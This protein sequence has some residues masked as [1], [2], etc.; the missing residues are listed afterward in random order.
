[1]A[2]L[3]GQELAVRRAIG[4]T[5]RRLFQALLMTRSL[6]GLRAVDLGF[7]PGGVAIARVALPGDRY[8]SAASQRAFF[9]RLLERVRVPALR[10]IV[11]SLDG[12]LPLCQVKALPSL[13]D[14]TL[15]ADRFA[16]LVLVA[17]AAAALLAGVGVFGV[18][19]GD[20][21]RRRKEIGIRLALGARGSQVVLLLLRQALHRAAVG[22]A[23]GTALALALARAMKALLFGVRPSDPASLIAAAALVLVVALGAT[24]VPAIRAVRLSPL[25]AL[26]EG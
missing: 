10:A 14:E 2:R 24:L 8:A 12:S 25:S 9:D 18:F 7:D 21:T 16:T 4:A 26:R 3:R 15:A 13:V 17:F 1:V 5:E 11:A 23:A 19:A 20:V 22:I 6:A